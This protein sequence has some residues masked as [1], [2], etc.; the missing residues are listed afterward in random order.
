VHGQLQLDAL[1]VGI[2]MHSHELAAV[3]P[4]ATPDD[5][6]RAIPLSAKGSQEPHKQV[7]LSRAGK[8]A[9]V[10]LPEGHPRDDQADAVRLNDNGLEHSS[11]MP[12]LRG[13]LIAVSRVS[14]Q[15]SAMIIAR[16]RRR[17]STRRFRD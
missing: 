13:A 9:S 8:E 12:P 7:R 16:V 3:H 10:E 6:Q 4:Q 1:F 14:R 17:C 11:L 15:M 5:Q 2:H